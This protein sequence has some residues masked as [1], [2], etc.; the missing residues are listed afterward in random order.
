MAGFEVML[1]AGGGVVS[2]VQVKLA[3]ALR[4]PAMSCALT[5]KLCLP[6]LKGPE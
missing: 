4:F 6:S 2:M 3:A 5:E 1:G